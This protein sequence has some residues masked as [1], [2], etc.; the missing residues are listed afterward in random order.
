MNSLDTLLTLRVVGATAAAMLGALSSIPAKSHNHRLL[1]ALV[2]FAAGGLLGVSI[3]HIVPEAVELAGVLPAL[4]YVAVG[5]ALFW[6]VGRFLYFICPACTAT[7]QE[8]GYLS[9]GLLM[10][11][12]MALHSMTDGIAMTAGSLASHAEHL[13]D[14]GRQ[15]G[16][17]VFVAVSYHK[18]PEG[19]ALMTVCRMAGYS[20][21]KA[22]GV[23]LL[24]ELTTGLGA[25]IGLLLQ[26]MTATGLGLL[27]GLVAGSFLYVVF[28]AILKEMWVH[29]KSPILLY[30]GVGLLSI[31]VLGHIV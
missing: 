3:F 18:I 27:L 29:E 15:L 7:H 1:C 24:V 10:I 26:G 28:F 20:L 22:L 12:A 25:L 21:G 4:A 31:L 8:K 17:L 2:S 14:G 9:L 5:M 13:P 30:S 6:A 16:L 11:V 19:M 23:T